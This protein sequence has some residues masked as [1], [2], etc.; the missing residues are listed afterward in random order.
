MDQPAVDLVMGHTPHAN[1]MAARYRQR[2][3]DDRLEAVAEHVREW[4]FG[5]AKTAPVT[6]AHT[7]KSPTTKAPAKK[8]KRSVKD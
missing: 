7:K 5:K 6:E 3:S 1:D 2:V 8:H 4:L